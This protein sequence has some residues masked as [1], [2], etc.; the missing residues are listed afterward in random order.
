[1]AYLLHVLVGILAVIAYVVIWV[2][3]TKKLQK[4]PRL[5]LLLLVALAITS[6][7]VVIQCLIEHQQRK[8][9]AA[10]GKELDEIRNQ[11]Q[12]FKQIAESKH[13]R[14]SEQDALRE[15]MSDML[16]EPKLILLR[17]I[18]ARRNKETGLW[19]AAYI[20][21]SKYVSG[22]RDISIRLQ[23]DGPI[24]RAEY[25]FVG[26]SVEDSGSSKPRISG[27]GLIFST[28]YLKQGNELVLDVVSKQPVRLIGRQLS[29]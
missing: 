8:D 2:T 11:F 3:S 14:L 1:M 13:P 19:A 29:P 24:E 26:A 5:K 21:R 16:K 15:L 9:A 22:I 28:G 7:V 10:V 27:N 25:R 6:L 12:P 20:F 23:F 18:E 4:S 17:E